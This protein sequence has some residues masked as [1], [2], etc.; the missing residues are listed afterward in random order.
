LL[1]TYYNIILFR[2]SWI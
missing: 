2:F 1:I